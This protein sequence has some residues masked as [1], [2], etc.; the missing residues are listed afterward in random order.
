M[1]IYITIIKDCL[2]V[3]TSIAVAIIGYKSNKKTKREIHLELEK[4]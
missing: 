4:I 1:E 3:A 2:V